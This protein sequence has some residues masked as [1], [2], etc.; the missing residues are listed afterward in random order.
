MIY[1]HDTT[2]EGKVRANSSKAVAGVVVGRKLGQEEVLTAESR[3]GGFSLFLQRVPS[4]PPR[5][6][7]EGRDLFG[8][9]APSS[10][11]RPSFFLSFILGR[12]LGSGC[13]PSAHLTDGEVEAQRG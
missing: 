2:E 6:C 10:G 1:S 7:R 4:P 11:T 13:S 12:P 9:W 3:P 8:Y 5:E